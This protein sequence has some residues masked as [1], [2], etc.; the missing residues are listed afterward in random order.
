MRPRHC[1]VTVHS[2]TVIQNNQNDQSGLVAELEALL[3]GAA[4]LAE[5][6][7]PDKSLALIYLGLDIIKEQG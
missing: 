5:N 6:G 7:D 3:E 2:T 4:L 1:T